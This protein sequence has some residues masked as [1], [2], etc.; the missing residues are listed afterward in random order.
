MAKELARSLKVTDRRGRKGYSMRYFG[1]IGPV[2]D[3]E[4][5]KYESGIW[6]RRASD[7]RHECDVTM[8]CMTWLKGTFRLRYLSVVAKGLDDTARQVSVEDS[9]RTR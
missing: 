5:K 6:L 7:S 4:V 3:I 1:V 8:V 9:E 2:S